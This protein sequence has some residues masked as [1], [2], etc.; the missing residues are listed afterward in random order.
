MMMKIRWIKWIVLA[1]LLLF[2]V[3]GCAPAAAT[4][5]PTPTGESPTTPIEVIVATSIDES[6][7]PALLSFPLGTYTKD[8]WTIEF[9]SAIVIE[10]PDIEHPELITVKTVYKGTANY[11]SS[12]KD[13]QKIF[14]EGIFIPG[15]DILVL[16]Q[17]PSSE[18]CNADEGTYNWSF[19]SDNSL[20][21]LTAQPK[22]GDPCDER[23][24]VLEGQWTKVE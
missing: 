12:I 2:L 5:A 24:Q 19:N 18:P 11:S 4:E 10:V 20:L 1:I 8:D 13:S 21:Q 7:V 15:P 3:T 16:K 23:R 17:D 9:S 22:Y 14:M 6:A